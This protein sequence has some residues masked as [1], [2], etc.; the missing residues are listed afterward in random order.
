ML[1][2]IKKS[3]VQSPIVLAAPLH[4][5]FTERPFTQTIL[6]P[7]A[8]SLDSVQKVALGLLLVPAGLGFVAGLLIRSRASCSTPSTNLSTKG[9]LPGMKRN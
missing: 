3:M 7:R 6:A 4:T 8:F 2:R 5:A 9:Q 1:R